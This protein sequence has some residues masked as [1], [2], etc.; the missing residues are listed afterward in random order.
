MTNQH[1]NPNSRIKQWKTAN[2]ERVQEYMKQWREKNAERLAKYRSDHREEIRE[3]SLRRYYKNHEKNKAKGREG[4]K[5]RNYGLTESDISAM[6]D[7][8]G[9][10]CAICGRVPPRLVVDHNHKS[11]NVRKLLCD[12]CNGLVGHIEKSPDIIERCLEYARKDGETEWMTEFKS[13]SLAQSQITT[14][15]LAK[16]STSL[17]Q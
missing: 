8:Q 16:F 5:I 17:V 11:G 7:A 15:Q 9:G 12:R 3:N 2:G 6:S 1:S 13:E 14:S 10:R 4:N